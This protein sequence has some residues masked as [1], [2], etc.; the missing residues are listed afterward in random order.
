M[1]DGPQDAGLGEILID[2]NGDDPPNA[3]QADASEDDFD[4]YVIEVMATGKLRIAEAD[5]K[6]IEYITINTSIRDGL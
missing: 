2:V 6:A 5:T 1:T 3:R 4:Q